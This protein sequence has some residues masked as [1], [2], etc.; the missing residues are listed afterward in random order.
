MNILIS[1][2]KAYLDVACTLIYSIL[3]NSTRN[4]SLFVVSDDL[5]ESDFEYIVDKMF[6]FKDRLHMNGVR[7]DCANF[8]VI[9][10]VDAKRWPMTV[11][12]RIIALF[13]LPD[14]LDRI[15]YLDADMI[16]DG[17]LSALYTLDLENYYAAMCEDTVVSN[18]VPYNS[19]LN[20]PN[21]ELYYNS[22][23]ILF[24]LT[25][26]RRE[27]TLND[28]YKAF[29]SHFNVLRFPDQDLLN[30]VFSKN[31]RAVDFRK[32]NF[33]CSNGRERKKTL[34]LRD[35]NAVIYHFAGG[36]Y[37][38]PWEKQYTGDYFEIF[39]KYAKKIYGEQMYVKLK[40]DQ[41]FKQLY[42]IKA[43][44]ALFFEYHFQIKKKH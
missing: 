4:L 11:Y 35:A 41:K 14:Q 33:I 27:L 22:G 13:E 10:T 30:V 44:M 5:N 28:F 23:M 8:D 29:R 1:I 12:Y 21:T 3:T 26:I 15:L 34:H 38:K 31:I 25:K 16:V 40:S 39:W 19:D 18:S 2:N 32:Y 37:H 20:I 42:R 7:V 6:E 24:N 9:N 43:R 17:D 36:K